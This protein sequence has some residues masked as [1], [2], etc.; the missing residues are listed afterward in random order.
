MTLAFSTDLNKIPTYFVENI[1]IGLENNRLIEWPEL[2]YLMSEYLDKPFCQINEELHISE[3]KPKPKIH[4]I[5]TDNS[6]RWKA[7]NL[8][9]FV[10]NN[11]TPNR[12]QFAPVLK[13]VS[14]QKVVIKYFYN[15]ETEAFDLPTVFIDTEPMFY[16]QLKELAINDGFKSI[17]AF[18]KYFNKDFKGKIIH[19]TDK[20]Y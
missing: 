7:G 11:R 9:H 1:L 17:E 16:D 2:S 3:A 19:W 20:K 12:Y 6:N 15:P 10:I 18:F 8:I 4:T 13:C 5:R 14:T